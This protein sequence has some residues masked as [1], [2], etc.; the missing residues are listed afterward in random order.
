MATHPP[1]KIFK[2]K[3]LLGTMQSKRNVMKYSLKKMNKNIYIK[4]IN[5]ILMMPKISD[6]SGTVLTTT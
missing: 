3:I 5:F 6:M 2:T 1:N 4:N